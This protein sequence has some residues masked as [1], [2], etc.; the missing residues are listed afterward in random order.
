HCPLFPR[1]RPPRGLGLRA[2]LLLFFS[3]FEKVF[4]PIN[5]AFPRLLLSLLPAAATAAPAL[6]VRRTEDP[7]GLVP[8]DA[9]TVG[10]VHWNALRASPLAARVFADVDHISG[11]GDGARF[12]AETGLSPRV[13]IDTVVIAMSAAAPRSP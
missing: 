9:V 6:A 2:L 4:F 13:D 10:V 7:L 8:A 3:F 5:P 11:D 1:V 12:L